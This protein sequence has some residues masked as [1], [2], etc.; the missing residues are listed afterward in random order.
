MFQ[1]IFLSFLKDKKF[2]GQL[3]IEVE[4]ENYAFGF[5][6]GGQSD[7]ERV[8]IKVVK[9]N[10]FKRVILYGDVGFGEAFFM[11]EFETPDLKKLLLWFAKNKGLLPGFENKSLG[12]FFFEWAK[13][14]TN[15]LHFSH[16]NTKIGSRK[17][18]KE[19]YDVS[20]D[21]FRLWLDETMAYSSAIFG[22]FE[23]LKEAQ[24]NKYKIICEKLN[25]G[26]DDHVLE[27][28]TG[29]GGFAIYAAKNYGCLITTTTISQNQFDFARERI[30]AEGLGERIKIIMEDYRDL[31]GKY[32]KIVSIEMMEALGYEYVPGYL[33]KC[34]SLFKSEGKMFFQ[35]IT[36]PDTDFDAHLKNP[37]YIKIHIFPGGELISLAQIKNELKKYPDFQISSI[38][39][40]GYD[41]A[42]TLH[43]WRDNFMSKKTEIHKLGFDEEF[44]R[45]WYY[46]FVYCEAGFEAGYIDDVQMSIEK[47]K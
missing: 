35:C 26:P 24:E 47:I 43:A 22:K 21:F 39:N 20:N 23:T 5:S 30:M 33:E 3:V 6:P 13:Y 45:K 14:F 28:G 44:Y 18:I 36:Y 1:K 7:A 38:Q 27:I 15:A 40:I 46:Y 41:Y 4:G 19:H 16:Q 12:S 2:Q 42:R 8:F 10:F 11:N 9:P 31:S 25:L 29:W 32:D 17:N 34:T 37:N